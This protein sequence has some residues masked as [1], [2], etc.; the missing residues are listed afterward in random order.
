MA[1]AFRRLRVRNGALFQSYPIQLL[2]AYHSNTGL[3]VR[4]RARCDS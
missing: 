4:R 1:E 2:I 3:V